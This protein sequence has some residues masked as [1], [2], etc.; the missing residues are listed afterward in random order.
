MFLKRVIL[1][2]RTETRDSDSTQENVDPF[3]RHADAGLISVNNAKSPAEMKDLYPYPPTKVN[4]LKVVQ[5]SYDNE[6]VTLQ[7][8]AVGDYEEQ[9]TGLTL[10]QAQVLAVVHAVLMLFAIL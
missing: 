2:D 4:D 5:M 6:T 8:T 1:D 7:W 3:E 9:E 10:R